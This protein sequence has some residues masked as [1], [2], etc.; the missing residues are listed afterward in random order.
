MNPQNFALKIVQFHFQA[1]LHPRLPGT[2]LLIT[3]DELQSF[4]VE[5]MQM[6]QGD[7]EWVV[8]MWMGMKNS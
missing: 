4:Y 7:V 5:S 2:G 1:R 8:D 6:K 3:F